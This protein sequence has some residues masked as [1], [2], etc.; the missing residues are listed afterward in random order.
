MTGASRTTLG[1]SAARKA[2]ATLTVLCSIAVGLFVAEHAA[3][4]A[5]GDAF[6]F[7]DVF[8]PDAELGVRLRA[9]AETRIRTFGGHVTDVVIND[10]GFRGPAWPASV[11]PTGRSRVLL[12]GD[13]QVFG[14]HAQFEET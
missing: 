6:P 4:A 14:L 11:E 13:S 9:G 2:R 1:S 7:L 10:Q 12:V 3:A 5:R 8:E